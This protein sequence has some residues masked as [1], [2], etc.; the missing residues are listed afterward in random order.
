VGS[1]DIK[2]AGPR[3]GQ[4]EIVNGEG[5]QTQITEPFAQPTTISPGPSGGRERQLM[6][7]VGPSS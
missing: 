7:F 1:V 6:Q 3:Q 2:G 5:A 4:V